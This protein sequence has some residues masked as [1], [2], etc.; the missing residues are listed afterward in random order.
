MEDFFLFFFSIPAAIRVLGQVEDDT[1][2]L[3]RIREKGEAVYSFIVEGFE[4][5]IFD[6]VE[7]LEYAQRLSKIVPS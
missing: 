1:C 5:I 7:E 4:T 2:I 6:S 3:E